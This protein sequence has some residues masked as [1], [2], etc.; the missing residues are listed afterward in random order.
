MLREIQAH[1]RI[2]SLRH[3]SEQNDVS[4][5]RAYTMPQSRQSG[6]VVFTSLSLTTDVIDDNLP[7]EVQIKGRNQHVHDRN[8][9][10]YD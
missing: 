4:L 2:S 6:Q 9:V 5:V 8:H 1:S 10:R 3:G 7:H